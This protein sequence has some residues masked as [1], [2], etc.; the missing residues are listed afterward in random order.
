MV[1][2]E[3]RKEDEFATFVYDSSEGNL[4]KNEKNSGQAQRSVENCGMLTTQLTLLEKLR[5][6]QDESAWQRFVTLYSPMLSTWA[7]RAG[8]RGDDVGDVVQEVLI[9]LMGKLPG[10]QYDAAKSFRGWM[11]TVLVNKCREKQRRARLPISTD[12]NLE[13][14]PIPDTDEEER[15]D[16]R[17]LVRRGLELIRHEFPVT[18]WEAFWQYVIHEKPVVEVAANL[19][20]SAGTVYAAKSRVMSRLRLDLFPFVD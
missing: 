6:S 12:A 9:L 16:R 13:L 15:D 18:Q 7:Q 10:F 1:F 20:I 3:N 4:A 19:G 5:A 17:L 2:L 14:V 11:R 8:V